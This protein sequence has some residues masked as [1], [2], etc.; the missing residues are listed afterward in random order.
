MPR[1]LFTLDHMIALLRRIYVMLNNGR[2]NVASVQEELDLD[3]AALSLGPVRGDMPQVVLAAV[4]ATSQ[5]QDTASER[6]RPVFSA[7]DRHEE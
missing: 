5:T 6:I 3:A 2:T 1:R 7:T 4:A